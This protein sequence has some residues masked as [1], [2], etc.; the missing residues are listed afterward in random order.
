VVTAVSSEGRLAPVAER[1]AGESGNGRRD[2]G[3]QLS[4]AVES[5]VG[6]QQ[7]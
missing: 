5:L 1:K 3:K 2:K 4:Y 6:C 7:Q